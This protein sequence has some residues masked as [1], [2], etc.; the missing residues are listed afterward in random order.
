MEYE[1]RYYYSREKLDS[2]IEKLKEKNNLIMGER[3]Y[4]KTCQYDHPCEEMSFYTKKIDGR[5]RIRI[6]KSN[7]IAK[8]KVSW[9]RRIKT[10]TLN[11]VNE[12][13]E[14]ELEIKYKE[15]ENLLFLV[16]SVLKMKSVES[17][18]RYRTIFFNDEIEIS[19]DEYPFGIALEIENKSKTKNPQ[20]IVEKWTKLLDL[21]IKKA[22]RL[23]WDD[24]YTQ[25][26]REQNVEIFKNVSFELPMPQVFDEV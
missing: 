17:Y 18:E 25:L 19:I 14:V 4:E 15:Y 2:I 26:C 24:K 3:C 13:E 16:N 7:T 9:K 1:V 10:T 20:G 22:Y 6:T 5:F 23:S 21:D 11:N 12:E 8:C